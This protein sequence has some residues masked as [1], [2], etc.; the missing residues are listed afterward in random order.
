M[1][2]ALIA[3]SK[4]NVDRKSIAKAY[5]DIMISREEFADNLDTLSTVRKE[6]LS[7]YNLTLRQYE[8]KIESMKADEKAWED[9]YKDVYIYLDSVKA[10]AGIAN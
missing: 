10:E 1:L 7:K 4:E 3:C 8:K 9:F 2:I 5:V 6:I